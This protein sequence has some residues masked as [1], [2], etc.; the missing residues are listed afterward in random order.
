MTRNQLYINIFGWCTF[1]VIQ[2][3]IYVDVFKIRIQILFVFD[4]FYSD[5]QIHVLIPDGLVITTVKCR[6]C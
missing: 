6:Y 2:R 5:T 4:T 1:K 3:V